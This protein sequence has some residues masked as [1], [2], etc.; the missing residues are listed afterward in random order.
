MSVRI[1]WFRRDLRLFDNAALY[2]ALSGDEPVVPIF[3]FDTEILNHLEDKSDRRVAFIH[4][5]L[6]DMQQQLSKI[7]SSLE[8]YNGTPLEVFQQ[9]INKYNISAVYTNHDYEPYAIGRDTAIANLLSSAGISFYTSK[10]Q[11][12]FE[13]LEV[14]KDDG[15]PYTVFTPYANKW[16]AT[17]EKTGIPDYPSEKKSA[18]FFQQT[19]VA[20]PSLISI[21]FF[22][23]GESFP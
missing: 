10:D 14:T 8:V 7:G 16:R 20:M 9:L 3:I 21:G 23:T 18:Q 2:Q 17:L 5:A 1:H 6:Q 4:R 12:I 19:P 13:K 11:V 22:D 15:T